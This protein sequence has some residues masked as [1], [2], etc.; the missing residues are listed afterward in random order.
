[1]RDTPR[2]DFRLTGVETNGLPR[3]RDGPSSPLASSLDEPLVGDLCRTNRR[4]ESAKLVG[5]G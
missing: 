4:R 5:A 1:M 2:R 3:C